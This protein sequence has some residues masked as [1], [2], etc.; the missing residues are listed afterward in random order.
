MLLTTEP[1]RRE[2]QAGKSVQEPCAGKA[3][4]SAFSGV[5]TVLFCL[6]RKVNFLDNT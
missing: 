3:V 2:H 6:N 4:P 1:L 5:C